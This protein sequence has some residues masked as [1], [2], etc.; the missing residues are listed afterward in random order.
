MRRLARCATLGLSIFALPFAAAAQDKPKSDA[1]APKSPVPAQ[2]ATPPATPPAKPDPTPTPDP[3]PPI[4]GARLEVVAE[5]DGL[6]AT[7]VAVSK[8]G[9]LFVCFPRWRDAFKQ[10]LIEIT[11]D[12]VHKT[13]PSDL[14]DGYVENTQEQRGLQFVCLQSIKVDEHDRLWVL[15]AAAPRMEGVKRSEFDGGGPKLIEIDLA[16]NK[17]R[18]VFRVPGLSALPESYLNDFEIDHE[19]NIGFITDSGAGGLILVNLKTY[20]TKRVLE[21]HAST[22][23]DPTFI[24]ILNGSELRDKKGLVPKVHADGIAL[25]RKNG[26]LYYQPLIGKKLYR[27]KTQVLID[28]LPGRTITGEQKNTV[29]AAVEEVDETVM[30]DGM[31][32]DS[33][34]NLYF[35]AVEKEAIMVRTPDSELRELV[36]GGPIKWP[37]S[38]AI[39]PKFGKQADPSGE[40]YLYF[41]T[42]QIHLT[43]WFSPDGSNPKEPYRVLRTKLYGK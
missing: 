16:T 38:F 37:D 12:G 32:F 17:H 24:P 2:P 26:Y 40:Q 5:F 39:G 23:A 10:S 20:E 34:G 31:I 8:T 35:T 42:S 6:Q 25:D 13:Y 11:T 41:T 9:R 18:R 36:S 3:T 21:R 14:W 43:D 22:K 4:P 27:I 15:D 7:G 28:V 33:A 30:T 19:H 1:P 29:A